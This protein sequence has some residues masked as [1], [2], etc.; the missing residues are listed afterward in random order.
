MGTTRA[1]AQRARDL[2]LTDES[3]LLDAFALRMDAR[4]AAMEVVEPVEDFDATLARLRAW[5][6][7]LGVEARLLDAPCGVRDVR[8]GLVTREGD[9][10]F[11]NLYVTGSGHVMR[12]TAQDIGRKNVGTLPAF[13]QHVVLDYKRVGALR[14]VMNDAPDS[15]STRLNAPQ[16]PEGERGRMAYVMATLGSGLHY[17]GRGQQALASSM[18]WHGNVTEGVSLLEIG[19]DSL[20]DAHEAAET[21]A[22]SVAMREALERKAECDARDAKQE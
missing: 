13:V 20:R 7:R 11:A 5:C 12:G 1:L 4:A 21:V 15:I 19:L 22:A 18:G 16:N 8:V 10:E 2:G 9:V 17:V 3:A 14:P 6:A